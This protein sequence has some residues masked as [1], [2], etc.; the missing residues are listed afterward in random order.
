MPKQT[1]E[2][3]NTFEFHTFRIK[4]PPDTFRDNTFGIRVEHRIISSTRAPPSPYRTRVP[5]RTSTGSMSYQGDSKTLGPPCG[6]N[7]V[8]ISVTPTIF[9]VK[10]PSSI[11]S[12]GL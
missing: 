5:G 1:N 7:T 2:S 3:D 6:V 10:V 4:A 12:Q 8:A 9:M 11:E